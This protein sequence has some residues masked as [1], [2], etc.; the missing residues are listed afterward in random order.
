[1]VAGGA[2]AVRGLRIQ[3]RTDL[4]QRRSGRRE[5]PAVD[6]RGA[7]GRPVEAEYQP[8]GGGLSCAIRTQKA[9]HPAG[10]HVE[11]QL[12]RPRGFCRSPW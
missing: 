9:G 3:Q 12:G 11:G 7:G 2:A 5:G 4:P 8:H 1:M 6:G 10:M